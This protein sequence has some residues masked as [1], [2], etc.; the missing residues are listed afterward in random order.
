MPPESPLGRSFID[1]NI[2]DGRCTVLFHFGHCIEGAHDLARAG[3]AGE[4]ACSIVRLFDLS[5][6]SARLE[7]TLR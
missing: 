5:E 6:F 1:Q 3:K 4:A 2:R 7:S